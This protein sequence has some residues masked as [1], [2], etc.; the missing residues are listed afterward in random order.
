MQTRASSGSPARKL[1]IVPSAARTFCGHSSKAA[2]ATCI[3]SRM[4]S[5]TI[6]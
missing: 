5:A 1:S 6:S 2:A 4:W 3:E